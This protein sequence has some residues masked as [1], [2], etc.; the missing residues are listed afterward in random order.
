[1]L[2][3]L[4]SSS[5]WAGEIAILD[6]LAKKGAEVTHISDA[7]ASH[8]RAKGYN[9]WMNISPPDNTSNGAN[10]YWWLFRDKNKQNIY[11]APLTYL[12]SGRNPVVR[13]ESVPGS[14]NTYYDAATGNY[15]MAYDT[16]TRNFAVVPNTQKVWFCN[17]HEFWG[18]FG[19][20]TMIQKGSKT[21][22]V[23]DIPMA[24]LR[25]KVSAVKID[26]QL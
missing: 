3:F 7:E 15:L 22:F 24:A 26:T 19:F 17:G 10:S 25:G 2:A 8:L 1:M 6:G 23:Y 9:Y 4:L 20:F 12:A 16:I 21:Q 13:Q 5:A 18:Q 11:Y 14:V